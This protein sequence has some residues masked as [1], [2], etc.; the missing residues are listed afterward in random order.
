MAS[1]PYNHNYGNAISPPYPSNAQ[2]PQPKRR[3]SDMPTSAPSLKRRKTSMLSA[4]SA[5]SAL[6]PL[7]QTSF[8]PENAPAY[9]RSPSVDTMSFVSGSAAGGPTKKK[10]ASGKR[11][12][13]QNDDAT[14][15]AGGGAPTTISG[16]SGKGKGK[17]GPLDVDVEEEDE[18]DDE[19]A[20]T[21]AATEAEKEK[22]RENRSLLIRELDPQQ[23]ERY[24]AWR[25]SKLPD[26]TVRRVR[27]IP[28]VHNDNIC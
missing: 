4:T 15:T 20:V 19:N 13:A 26:S 14:S 5:A 23:F 10:R 17:R 21:G 27:F 6:H 7:R 18:G 3:V 25:F 2:L 16:I 28:L 9:M 8:P 12:G 24:E 22:E 1:P 11:K